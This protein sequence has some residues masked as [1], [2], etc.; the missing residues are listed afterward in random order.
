MFALFKTFT[1]DARTNTFPFT[2][3]EILT[4]PDVQINTSPSTGLLKL[5]SSE[6][7]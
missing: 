7:A 3:D 5:T 6:P 4:V 1:E 2:V